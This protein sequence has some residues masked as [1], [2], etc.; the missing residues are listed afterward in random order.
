MKKT[1]YTLLQAIARYAVDRKQL[2]ST[3]DPKE[4]VDDFIIENSSYLGMLKANRTTTEAISKA[5]VEFNRKELPSFYES[6][7][8]PK[9]TETFAV[10][11]QQIPKSTL[12]KPKLKQVEASSMESIYSGFEYTHNN[13]V[14]RDDLPST[15]TLSSR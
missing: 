4:C 13:D 7:F 9:V 3:L 2:D 14:S 5:I 15:L 6:E 10:I 12:V 11:I 1:V 8:V